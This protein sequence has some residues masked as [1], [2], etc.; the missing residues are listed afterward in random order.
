MASLLF[1]IMAIGTSCSH[2]RVIVEGEEGSV[3]I[4][5][6]THHYRSR[7]PRI[8]PG[9]MPPPG[10]CRIWYPETFHRVSNR[11][12]GNVGNLNDMF[13]PVHGL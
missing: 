4:E 8:P 12:Q 1:V 7:L 9:H 2:G 3:I 13:L 6:G 5:S 11:L 10:K